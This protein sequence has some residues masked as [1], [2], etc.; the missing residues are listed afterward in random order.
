MLSLFRTDDFKKPKKG[1]RFAVGRPEAEIFELL[2]IRHFFREK[3]V[4]LRPLLQRNVFS[5]LVSWIKTQIT[6]RI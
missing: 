2:Y 4:P 3:N 5:A 1:F 6:A